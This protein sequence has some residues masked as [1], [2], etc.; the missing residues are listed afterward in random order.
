LGSEGGET[1]TGSPDAHAMFRG[2]V[3]DQRFRRGLPSVPGLFPSP[4]RSLRERGPLDLHVAVRGAFGPVVR[5]AVQGAV[6]DEARALE[7]ARHVVEGPHIDC[8]NRF[9]SKVAIVPVAYPCGSLEIS[10]RYGGARHSRPS[11]AVVIAEPSSQFRALSEPVRRVRHAAHASGVSRSVRAWPSG[12]G[13][14]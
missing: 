12:K 1:T 7:T 2:S 3:L 10:R 9:P 14:R 8:A 5:L 11:A 6:F 4:D 13:T